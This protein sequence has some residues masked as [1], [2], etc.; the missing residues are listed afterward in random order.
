MINYDITY[1]GHASHVSYKGKNISNPEDFK[2]FL[3]DVVYDRVIDA[4][5]AEDFR[6]DLEEL[7]T[8]EMASDTLVR[9]LSSN[10]SHIKSWEIG[11]AFIECVLKDEYNIKW[12]WNSERDKR[13]PKA[14]L[15]GA[16]LIGFY[17]DGE[18]TK[19]IFGEV[20]T[21]TEKK[22]PPKVMTGRHGIINQLERIYGTRSIRLSLIKWLHIRCKNT[23]M[24][25]YF[26]EAVETYLNSKEK[27]VILYGALMRDIDPQEKDL[28]NR[29]NALSKI[30][31]SSITTVK[32]NAWYCPCSIA[33]WPIIILEGKT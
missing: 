18:T 4:E 1:Q 2:F 27:S 19:F 14:S 21:S 8:T 10:D 16:D 28:I 30:I 15:P 6:R 24:W 32:L 29:A 22:A 31:D 13:T 12:P 20:K 5:H 23:E 3:N 9:L 26:Q 25:P 11:E 17:R 33:D 7:A